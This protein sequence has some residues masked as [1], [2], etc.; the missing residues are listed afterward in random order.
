[1]IDV[2]PDLG[3]WHAALLRG[4]LAGHEHNRNRRLIEEVMKY[5]FISRLYYAAY[6]SGFWS[7]SVPP[8][9]TIVAIQLGGPIIATT[10]KGRTSDMPRRRNTIDPYVAMLKRSEAKAIAY[11]LL[12]V[13]MVI[14]ALFVGKTD[15]GSTGSLAPV[16]DEIR[17]KI[18]F[19]LLAAC[20]LAGAASLWFAGRYIYFIKWPERFEG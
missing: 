18:S 1:M 17:Q 14:L 11:C 9:H 15:S 10:L 3:K 6:E 7:D 13:L 20:A 8:L 16:A 2:F 5:R 4:L 12:A 19:G